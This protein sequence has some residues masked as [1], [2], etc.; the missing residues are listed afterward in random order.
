MNQVKLTLN[1]KGQGAFI[2]TDAGE[3]IGEMKIGISNNDLI[4][5]HTEVLP[6]LE[7]KGMGKKLLAAMV[8]Y[9]RNNALKVKT[10]CIFVYGQFKRYPEKYVDIWQQA[11]S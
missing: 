7:G 10:L 9:A 5:Y 3:Q 4:I 2:I 11:P 6:S 8:E 1:D